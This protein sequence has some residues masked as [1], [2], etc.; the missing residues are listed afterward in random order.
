MATIC[1]VISP[2]QHFE[3]EA[4]D[5]EPLRCPQVM[6]RPGN[7]QMTRRN[8]FHGPI[9]AE[10]RG[11]ATGTV[12][13]LPRSGSSRRRPAGFTAADVVLGM[14]PIAGGALQAQSFFTR[15]ARV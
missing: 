15:M 6:T 13:A 14:T 4:L 2:E 5:P 8:G 7:T 11:P 10:P 1:L 3:S 9:I 12:Q